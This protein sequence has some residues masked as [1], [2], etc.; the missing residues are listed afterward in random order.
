MAA[1][2]SPL[3]VTMLAAHE[4]RFARIWG[5]GRDGQPAPR[6]GAVAPVG[7]FWLQ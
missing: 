6:G 7:D 1:S 5:L 3:S 2:G 4:S